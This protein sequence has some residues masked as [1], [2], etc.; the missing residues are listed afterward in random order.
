MGDFFMQEIPIDKRYAQADKEAVLALVA[1]ALYFVWWY[2]CAYGLGDGDP[3]L[4]SYVL[5]LPSWFFYSCIVG[6]PLITLVLWVMV[7]CCFKN[8][9]LE[10]EETENTLNSEHNTPKE[11]L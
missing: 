9:P 3:E 4:Y 8:I 2:A 11:K 5:G 10:T 6:Y 1:Y 7:R